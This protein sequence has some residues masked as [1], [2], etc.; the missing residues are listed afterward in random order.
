VSK[1]NKKLKAFRVFGLKVRQLRQAKHWTL[2]DAETHGYPSWRHLQQI[3]SGNKNVTLETIL[4]LSKLFD[5][6]P[7]ELL[8]DI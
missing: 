5:V 2:E 4:R 3:E 7:S 1:A 6:T 8:K